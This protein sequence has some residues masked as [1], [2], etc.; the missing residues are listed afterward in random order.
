MYGTPRATESTAGCGDEGDWAGPLRLSRLHCRGQCR[1]ISAVRMAS[2]HFGGVF[3]LIEQCC[4][5]LGRLLPSQCKAEVLTGR[6][7]T[8]A[9]GRQMREANG[10]LLCRVA[11]GRQGMNKSAGCLIVLAIRTRAKLLE[12]ASKMKDRL[13]KESERSPLSLW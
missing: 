2:K 6:K 5:T 12:N 13:F 1:C 8:G 3:F 11:S 4:Y 7:R 10:P 9:P